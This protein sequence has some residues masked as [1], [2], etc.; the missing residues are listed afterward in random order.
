[1]VEIKNT[2]SEMK[3][4]FSRVLSRL[5]TAKERINDLKDMPI[6]IIQ[7]ETQKEKNKQNQT[8]N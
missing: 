3:N 1:M 8:V 4:S 6:V 7:T 5:D 2:I